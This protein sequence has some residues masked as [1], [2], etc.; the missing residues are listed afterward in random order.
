MLP[1][2]HDDGAE[3]TG[4]DAFGEEISA[5]IFYCGPVDGACELPR[6]GRE[7][8]ELEV[9]WADD[10][11]KPRRVDAKLQMLSRAG[12]RT[13]FPNEQ[14]PVHDGQLALTLSNDERNQTFAPCWRASEVKTAR[15][16]QARVEGFGF[17]WQLAVQVV[18]RC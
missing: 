13:Q 6:Y 15:R 8:C 1:S 4:T 9:T 18:K 12:V 10:V 5:S 14:R 7:F 11:D 17:D 16:E 3:T 2:A